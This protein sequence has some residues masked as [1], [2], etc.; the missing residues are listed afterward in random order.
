MRKTRLAAVSLIA[1][2]AFTTAGA[3]ACTGVYVGK[4]V[5][6]EGTT[7]IARSEDQGSGAYNKMFKVQ[8]RV[9]KAGRFYV[10]EG[11]DQNGFR[12]PLPETTY[13][14]TYVPDSSD[15]GDG[16]YPASCTNEYGVAVVGTVSA[17]PSAEYEKAD[18]F[19]KTGTGLREAILPGLLACQVKTAREGVDKLAAL[20]DK[21]GSEE[22]NILFFSDKKE[23][24]IFE[25]YG[26]STYAAVKM[27]EDA[28]SVFGNQFMID[29]VDPK[30][31]AGVVLSKNLLS[32]IDKV[33]AVK[34]NGKYNLVK[35]ISDKTRDEYSNMRTWVGHR[36]LSPQTAGE[37]S[38]SEFYPLFYKPQNKVSVLD[39]MDIYRNRYEGTEYDMMKPENEA[40][41]PIGVTRSSDIHIIQTFDSLPSDTSQL[42]W[43]AMGNAPHSVFIPAFSGITD[44]YKAYQIDGSRFDSR[45]MYSA[46][47]RISTTAESD[48]EFLSR[49]VKDYW[50]IEEKMMLNS[51]KGEIGKVKKA[52]GKNEKQGRK[53]VT[54]LGKRYAADQFKQTDKLYGDLMWTAMDNLNDRPDNQRKTYFVADTRLLRA[55]RAA[56][57]T[58]SKSGKTYTLKSA[59]K[60]ITL[61]LGKTACQVT[62]KGRTGTVELT[63]SPYVY[64]G[65]VYAPAD[66]V[67]TL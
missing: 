29:T 13:K 51:I 27:P 4:A 21:Y 55:A 12:V 38:D 11:E 20:I 42:Q 54:E 46:F 32:T 39:V 59:D 57:Y 50:K 23:A 48:R 64:S 22:G 47:K 40:R 15:A 36:I 7:V 45:S 56:G 14:Y 30:N 24:W 65:Y 34:E 10:D 58:V 43:L 19:A 31:T 37:Y 18:P 66:F 5:S 2:M 52:Y 44:T 63:R 41:R 28:V 25:V 17:S 16:E 26:G 60:N 49:G 9:T 1:A 67:M 61:T 35:S 62:E 8:P 3:F 33:G 53:Y 6:A